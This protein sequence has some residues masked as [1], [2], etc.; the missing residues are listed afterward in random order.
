M[1]N[2]DLN[3]H[4]SIVT[5]E[6]GLMFEVHLKADHFDFVIQ[7]SAD[8]SDAERAARKLLSSLSSIIRDH[9]YHLHAQ[10][11]LEGHVP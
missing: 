4:I 11:Y 3:Q 5:L 6:G 2:Y 7:R 9:A 8:P 1:T 10:S